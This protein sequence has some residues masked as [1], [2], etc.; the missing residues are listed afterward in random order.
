VVLG[1]VKG[2]GEVW[3]R[4]FQL[5]Q[6]LLASQMQGAGFLGRMLALLQKV[7]DVFAGEGLIS[8]GIFQGAGDRLGAIKLAQGDDL[9]DV[10]FGVEAPLFQLLIVFVGL[11]AKGQK[12]QE[13]LLLARLLAVQEQGGHVVGQ[14]VILVAVVAAHR[15]GY[16]LFLVINQ[17]P[18]GKP[19]QGELARRILTRDRVTVAIDLDA[20]LTVDPDGVRD[21]RLVRQRMQ[22]LELFLAEEFLGRISGLPVNPHIGYRIE[23][24]AR[25]RIDGLKIRQLQTVEKVLFD[26][27][28]AVFDASFFLGLA[29]AASNLAR[30]L[31]YGDQRLL[32]LARALATNPALLLL[33]EPAAGMNEAETKVLI[34]YIGKIRERG[35]SILLVEHDMNL[36][37]TISDRISVLNFGK[38]I[39]EGDKTAIQSNDE[40]IEAYLGKGIRYA[41]SRPGIGVL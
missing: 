35:I 1:V 21:G 8:E 33:D 37:M 25:R 14:L 6:I 23:P 11:G 13:E 9:L 32:E 38:K 19:F 10:M 22:G 12:A 7:G 16:E 40:V 34:D 26:I 5:Q 18:V 36:V 29:D 15:L 41:Q 30:N 27:A 28:H 39:A 20:E 2:E 3:S 31:P 17:E 24:I 4:Q